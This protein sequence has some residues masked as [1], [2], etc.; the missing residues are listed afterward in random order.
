MNILSSIVFSVF[1]LLGVGFSTTTPVNQPTETFQ[2][3]PVV[4]TQE[5]AANVSDARLSAKGEKLIEAEFFVPLR[6]IMKIDLKKE[7]MSRCPSSLYYLL[8]QLPD[9]NNQFSSGTVSFSTGCSEGE[10]I[11]KFKIDKAE[12][13][14]QILDISTQKYITPAEWLKNYPP[15]QN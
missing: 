14:L 1:L 11:A 9:K 3:T 10:E 2:N 12:E 5:S 4:A 13:K 6:K 7:M 8:S 15:K